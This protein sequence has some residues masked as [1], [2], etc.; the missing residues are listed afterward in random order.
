MIG[1]SLYNG[2][3]RSNFV[4]LQSP[5]EISKRGI[6]LQ[7]LD[8]IQNNI[9]PS[10]HLT[11][12]SIDR[13]EWWM[14]MPAVRSSTRIGSPILFAPN[15]TS[16]YEIMLFDF[17]FINFLQYQAGVVQINRTCIIDDHPHKRK[18]YNNYLDKL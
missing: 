14:L 8:N 5:V 3:S 2:L 16:I 17:P 4:G 1:L 11:Q 15:F 7:L 9:N 6:L 10:I 13:P 12:T 18:I